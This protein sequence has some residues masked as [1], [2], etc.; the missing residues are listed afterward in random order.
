[1]TLF[2]VSKDVWGQEILQGMSWELLP[3]FFGL[4]VV[5]I[6]CHVLY[7]WLLAPKGQS[8]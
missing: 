2:R 6:L 7:R 4:G 1:M 8:R 5:F 3:V